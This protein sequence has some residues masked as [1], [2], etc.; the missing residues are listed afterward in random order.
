MSQRSSQSRRAATPTVG[1][2][3]RPTRRSREAIGA[4]AAPDS[5][6]QRYP[7]RLVWPYRNLVLSKDFGAPIQERIPSTELA[8]IAGD[9][10]VPM[11][12]VSDGWRG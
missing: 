11:S 3:D 7:N 8:R 4:G 2:R 12:D 6:R 5:S 9:G 1:G 10:H